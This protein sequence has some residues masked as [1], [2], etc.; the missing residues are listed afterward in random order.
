MQRKRWLIVMALV[1]LLIAVGAAAMF[2]TAQGGN[3]AVITAPA[4]GA[5]VSGKVAIAGTATHSRFSYYKVEYKS[6]SNPAV[7]VDSMVH[8]TQVNSGALATWD[9]S[10]VPDGAYDLILTVVDTTGNFIQASLSVKLD[11]TTANR[12]AAAPRRGCGA[13][14]ALAD[15]KTG[16]Y[17]L[18]YEGEERAAAR[19]GEHPKLP[20]DTKYETCMTCHASAANGKGVAAPLSMRD[21][22]HP[23]HIFSNTFGDRYNGSCFTCHNVSADG[24]YQVLVEK[25]DGN[26]K[27]VPNP[28]K[29]PIPGAVDPI[30]PK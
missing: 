6:G 25:M 5:T 14:H 8:N 23:A 2:A 26:D 10:K 15:P 28:A 7:L 30:P 3:A 19:G 13:C 9:S 27:G 17:T 20:W 12:L 4:A 18:A 29:I 24:K 16:K 22:V 1:V 11:N 21:I